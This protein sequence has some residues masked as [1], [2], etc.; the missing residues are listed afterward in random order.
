MKEALA[1]YRQSKAGVHRLRIHVLWVVRRKRAIL[2]GRLATALKKH[3]RA[4]ADEENCI[5]LDMDI[6]PRFCHLFLDCPADVS[7][8]RIQQRIKRYTASQLRNELHDAVTRGPSLWTRNYLVSTDKTL[9][10]E[11]IDAFIEK[12]PKI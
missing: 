5:I 6:A 7:P 3:I 9:S 4:I 12:Q 11:V 1:N 8:E 2:K 10:R